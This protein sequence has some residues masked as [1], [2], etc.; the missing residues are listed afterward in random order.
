MG[1]LK[2]LAVRVGDL[3]HLALLSSG[4]YSNTAFSDARTLK[5]E[6]DSLQEFMHSSHIKRLSEG[7][8]TIL[9]GVA[10]SDIIISFDK[11][12]EYAFSIIKQVRRLSHE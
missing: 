5:D 2:S 9:A 12:S 11:I 1:E 8:C 4:N 3:V 10:Y 6:I 7:R